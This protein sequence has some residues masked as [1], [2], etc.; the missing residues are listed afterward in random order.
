MSS[1][2]CRARVRALIGFTKAL[3]FAETD[4]FFVG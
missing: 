3:V 2:R 4:A 1:D